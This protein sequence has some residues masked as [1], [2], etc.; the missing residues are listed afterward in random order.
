MF[1]GLKTV[2]QSGCDGIIPYSPPT[3]SCFA[4]GW[5]WESQLRA[6]LGS[7]RT[8]LQ[9]VAGVKG[10]LGQPPGYFLVEMG[11]KSFS[12]N[13]QD[14]TTDFPTFFLFFPSGRRNYPFELY[15]E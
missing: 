4:S 10:Y 3:G 15:M 2:S 14:R 5:K 6:G 7:H 1:P 11:L 13:D 12:S 9:P 8:A